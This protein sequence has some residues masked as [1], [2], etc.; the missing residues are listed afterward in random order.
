MLRKVMKGLILTGIMAT[1]CVFSLGGATVSAANSPSQT[2]KKSAD[3]MIKLNSL[4]ADLTSSE[5]VHAG[6][7]SLTYSVNG[8]ADAARSNETKIDL[9]SS[10]NYH[11][12][13][14]STGQT[15]YAQRGTGPWY[16]TSVSNLP[17]NTQQYLSQGLPKSMGQ[18]LSAMQD[19]RL[20][21]KGLE[22]VNSKK[23]DHITATLT[24]QEMSTL[25]SQLNGMLPSQW[26]SNQNRITNGTVDLWIDPATSYLYRM[27]VDASTQIDKEAL[28]QGAGLQTSGS[29]SVPVD[30]KGQLNFSKFDQPVSISV[31]S[32]ATPYPRS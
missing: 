18:L 29:S 24:P 9:S 32:S 20:Q 26:Q 31:P 27:S 19:A 1:L 17:G 10:P 5:V 25:S 8:T 22:T 12:T 28:A 21:D 14:V 23:L 2:I 16:Q 30:V 11:A 6:S 7:S 3:A 15:V 4:H 13:I